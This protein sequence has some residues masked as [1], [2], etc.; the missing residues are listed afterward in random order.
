MNLQALLTTTFA[1]NACLI[2]KSVQQIPHPQP[3]LMSDPFFQEDP[4]SFYDTPK[5]FNG[6]ESWVNH[7]I[8]KKAQSIQ[9]LSANGIYECGFL[10]HL[11]HQTEAWFTA[12]A[13][14]E[15]GY[16]I[17]F[18]DPLLD[19]QR[20]HEAWL[21]KKD[22]YQLQADMYSSEGF[23]QLGQKLLSAVDLK[24]SGAERLAKIANFILPL[25]NRHYTSEDREIVKAVLKVSSND[26]FGNDI[27]H[28]AKL[29]LHA[30]GSVNL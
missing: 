6:F 17:R 7:L 24:S 9:I 28:L 13:R 4:L 16:A 22:T 21:V 10:V 27:R 25:S 15:H 23:K 14:D 3:K 1:V 12:D 18:K 30:L 5:V 26:D 11:G 20:P 8:Q 19:Q 29:T 2:E